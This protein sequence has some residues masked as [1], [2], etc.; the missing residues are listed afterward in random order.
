MHTIHGSGSFFRRVKLHGIKTE[1]SDTKT[2]GRES[3]KKNPQSRLSPTL[4]IKV[5]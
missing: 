4:G 1:R 3:R 2:K 5:R